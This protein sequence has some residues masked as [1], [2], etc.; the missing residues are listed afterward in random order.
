MFDEI[1]GSGRISQLV[2]DLK[3]LIGRE[4]IGVREEELG[5]V[6]VGFPGLIAVGFEDVDDLG[7]DWRQ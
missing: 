2:G 6:I 5:K 4:R 1:K 7:N 3:V